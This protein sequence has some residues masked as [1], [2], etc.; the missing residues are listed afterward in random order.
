MI[1]RD[2]FLQLILGVM[3][4]FADFPMDGPVDG[5]LGQTITPI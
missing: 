5:H 4:E 1:S 3:P 2:H